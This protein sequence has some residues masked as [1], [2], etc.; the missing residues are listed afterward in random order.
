[1]AKRLYMIFAGIALSTGIA[2]AQ[3]Q[4]TGTVVDDKGNPVI[5]ASVRVSGTQT[6]SVTDLDGK[7][8]VSAPANAQLEV[9]YVGMHPTK[10]KAGSNIRVVLQS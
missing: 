1:M 5:G 8:A 4:V 6:G 9:T 3:S 7:F 2:F 10:V